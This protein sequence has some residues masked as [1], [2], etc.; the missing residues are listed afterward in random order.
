METNNGDGII[1]GEIVEEN[2]GGD[3]GDDTIVEGNPRGGEVDAQRRA[4]D[5]E[6]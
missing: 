3:K 6:K 1:V 5:G 4:I 2:L